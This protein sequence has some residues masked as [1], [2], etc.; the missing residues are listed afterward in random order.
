MSLAVSV[1]TLLLQFFSRKIFL[2]YLGEEVLGL[3]TTATNLLQFLNI[4]ELGISSAVGF[5]LYKPLH[6]NDHRMVREIVTLQ[7]HLYRRIGAGVLAGAAVLMCFFPMIFSK[8]QLPL[9]YAY[10]CFGVLL[11]GSM[12]GYFFNY[13]QIVLDADQQGYKISYS[14][15]SVMIVKVVAQMLALSW[16]S[17]GFVWWLAIEGVFSLLGAVS[18]QAT[19]LRAFPY[20]HNTADSFRTLRRRYPEFTVK[21]KQLFYHKI[22]TFALTQSSPIIIYAFTTMGMVAKYGNYM[23]IISGMQFMITALFNG[24]TPGIGNL[25][26]E[27]DQGRIRNV[28]RQLFGIR[29]FIA[30]TASML[31]LLLSQRF[32]ALWIGAE[33]VL[34]TST[35]L[36]MCLILYIQLFRVTV[37]SFIEAC[38]L[39]SDIWAPVAESLLNIGLSVLF[40]SLWGLNGILAGVLV[41]LLVIVV[42]WKPYFMLSR[43]SFGSL[44]LYLG[45]YARHLAA[46]AVAAVPCVL[47]WKWSG[48][49]AAAG[50]SG[51]AVRGGAL[52]VLSAVVMLAAVC[53]VNRPFREFLRNAT[54]MGMRLVTGVI[55]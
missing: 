48:L 13:K 49:Q 47:A 27:G 54:G 9:W 22:A 35:L 39:Y 17:N 44:G 43:T 19:T 29:F 26:A 5:T 4:A 42:C 52:T 7:G 10:A 34:P 25:V 37:E 41:S 38:G 1:V 30:S 50:W 16:L 15:K 28:F 24:V 36:L 12:L 40:G 33:Y 8:M 20:L 11:F 18:L 51:F 55:R 46:F 32:I 6:D 45:L 53:V 3:N 23:I 14:Y 31:V 21:I 2:E